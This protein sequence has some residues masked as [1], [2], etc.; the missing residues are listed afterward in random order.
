MRDLRDQMDSVWRAASRLTAERGGRCVMFISAR[1][2]EGAS[3]LAAS[4]A[5][6]AARRSEKAAW[7][8]DLD[9]RNNRAFEAFEKGFAR[10]AGK[11]GR[12]YDASLRTDPIYTLSPGAV[13][14]KGKG[15]ASKLLAVHEIEKTRLLVTRFRNELLA[16]GQRVQ[17]RTQPGW[18]Q[19]VRRAADWIVVDA[20]ALATSPAG[21]AMAGQMDGV[22]LVVEADS[23]GAD[24]VIAL[25]REVES[26]GGKVAGVVLNRMRA[27]ARFADRLAG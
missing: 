6:L 2:G 17:L 9:L 4:F 19:S 1:E 13:P 18:W 24:E 11:P 25:A 15:A 12:A 14:G 27:D 21:L 10:G 16:R 7:L 23:T 5:L 26:H 22:I 20:P 3:S 8:I